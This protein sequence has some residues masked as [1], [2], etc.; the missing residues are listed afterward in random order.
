MIVNVYKSHIAYTF[1]ENETIFPL[2]TRVLGKMAL[3]EV[4]ES[5]M[6]LYNGQNRFLYNL[7]GTSP[8]AD[9]IATLPET[10]VISI[11]KQFLNVVCSL[12]ENDYVDKGAM[13]VH[14]NRLF[15]NTKERRLRCVVLPINSSYDLYD[16]MT[17]EEKY[18]NSL[19]IFS[20]YIFANNPGKYNEFYYTIMNYDLSDIDLANMILSY[21]F[22]VAEARTSQEVA[23]DYGTV[24]ENNR[25]MVLEHSSELGNIL[26]RIHQD[27]YILGK[28][29]EQAHGVIGITTSVS[30]KHCIIRR[31]AEGFTAE[32]L[33]SSNGTRINGY[34]ISPGQQYM[35]SHGDMLQLSDIVFL[36]HME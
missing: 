26:F 6:V 14:F 29:K 9:I 3:K 20:Q 10:E 1:E 28:S 31:T 15:Y 34:S 4:M 5:N 23:V 32:D 17:W 11:M 27:E 30:R 19:A 18:R 35:L 36:V 2:G 7:S 22:G 16:G 12:V 13:D 8:L 21:D 24:K 25:I 33:G